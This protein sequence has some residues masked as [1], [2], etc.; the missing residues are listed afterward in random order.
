M[1][2]SLHSENQLCSDPTSSRLQT[3]PLARCCQPDRGAASEW[4]IPRAF[5]SYEAMLADPEID[6][7]YNPLPNLLHA[8]WTIKALQ[9]GKH[10]LCE[11]PL[12][13]IVA[14]VDAII[15]AAKNTGKVV[16]EALMYRHHPQ[17]LNVKEIAD[18]GA[19]G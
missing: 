5:G 8:E 1:G 15:S 13:L 19:L 2:T 16:A 12:A 3:E 4:N 7:I 18:S 14:D 17:T 10:V 9:R 6:V 11:K